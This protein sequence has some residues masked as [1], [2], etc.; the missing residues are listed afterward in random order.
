MDR[1][2]IYKSGGQYYDIHSK[3]LLE[4]GYIIVEETD[5][6]AIFELQDTAEGKA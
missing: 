4:R 5:E 1:Q 3:E 2:T 6:Y